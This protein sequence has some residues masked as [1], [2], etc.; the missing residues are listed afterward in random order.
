MND[1]KA[2]IKTIFFLQENGTAATFAIL[3]A[4]VQECGEDTV[5]E[6]DDGL[7]GRP[8]PSPLQ[9]VDIA[10]ETNLT[11]CAEGWRCAVRVA[12]NVSEVY[13]LTEPW[14]APKSLIEQHIENIVSTCPTAANV[15]K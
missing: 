2:E 8:T 5:V 9:M 10:S 15:T 7:V 6:P 11:E 13:G 4:Y 12:T 14:E 3:L 1:V